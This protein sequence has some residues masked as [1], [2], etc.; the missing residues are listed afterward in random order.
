[1]SN[2]AQRHN[3]SDCPTTILRASAKGN[4]FRVSDVQPAAARRSLHTWNLP[5]S[6][7]ARR[8]SG[9][10][11]ASRA[12]ERVGLGDR[13]IAP[14]QLAAAWGSATRRESA[15]SL[16]NEL[17]HPVADEPTRNLDSATATRSWLFQE[18]HDRPDHRA[19]VSRTNKT[20]RRMRAARFTCS[21][22]IERTRG[23]T[24]SREHSSG[25]PGLSAPRCVRCKK[26]T[27]APMYEPGPWNAT[28]VV[29]AVAR[30]DRVRFSRSTSVQSVGRDHR[31]HVPDGLRRE[32]L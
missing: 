20:L 3:V 30:G 13:M 12:L 1:V 5:L 6:T 16:V 10:R 21:G 17:P 31:M 18:L 15:R 26:A 25:H 2:L 29:S 11:R 4:R 27:S 8:A 28:S 14:P 7:A 22:K 24:G 19:G 32:R 9:K 23:W